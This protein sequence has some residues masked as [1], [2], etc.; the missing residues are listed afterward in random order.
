MTNHTTSA[1]AIDGDGVREVMR[2]AHALRDPEEIMDSDGMLVAREYVVPAGYQVTTTDLRPFL[3]C[4]PRKTG[5]VY[6]TDAGSFINYVT[7]H[8][9]PGTTLYASRADGRVLAILNAD[10]QH[11]AGWSDHTA[12]LQLKHTPEWA[13][14]ANVNG[15]WLTQEAF[16]E[17]VEESTPDFRSPSAAAMLEIAQ[18]FEAKSG[19][20]FQSGSRLDNGERQLVYKETITAK[21]GQSGSLEVPS[22]LGIGLRPYEGGKGY[23][24][25]ARLRYRINGGHLSLMVKID[26]L[27]DVIETAF[28][29]TVA[30]LTESLDTVPDLLV[31]H[32]SRR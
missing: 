27:A 18:T 11:A 3:S 13:R 10:T 4:P 20:D 17:F 30:S 6:L 22:I 21:A 5:S 24:L 26:R 14:W 32:G 1:A 23:N 16:A 7:R 28:A 9:L 8:G 29:D 12:T 15:S 19:V 2:F 31:V 25:D